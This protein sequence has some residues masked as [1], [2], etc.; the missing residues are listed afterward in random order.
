MLVCILTR[1]VSLQTNILTYSLKLWGY[2]D[3]HLDKRENRLV[4]KKS[5]LSKC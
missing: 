2:C 3:Y 4:A 5:G 1:V